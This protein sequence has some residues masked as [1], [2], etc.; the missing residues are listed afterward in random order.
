MWSR[1][2]ANNQE[3]AAAGAGAG[4]PP[5]G[6]AAGRP[7]P[8]AAA[9]RPPAGG[10]RSAFEA[11]LGFPPDPFQARAFDAIDDGH[12]VLVAV[13]TG[14]GKTVVAEYA[15]A[16]AL[17]QG[18]KAFYTTPIKALSNQKYRDFVGAYGA[19][20]VGLLTGDNSINPD[21]SVVVM[22]TEVLRNMIYEGSDTL[23][24][25]GVVVLDEV[26][27]LQDPYRGAVWEEVIIHLAPEVRLVCLSATVSNAEE[28]GA[29]VRTVRGGT[30][31]VIDDHRPVELHHL[32]AVSVRGADEVL[33]LP[34]F[35]RDGGR[36]VPNPEGSRWDPLG[37]GRSRRSPPSRARL[38]QGRPVPPR[39]VE[40]LEALAARSMVPAIYFLFSR[41]GCDEAVQQCLAAGLRLTS[42][43]EAEAV[44]G[45]AQRRCEGLGDGDLRLLGHDAWLSGL[46]AG[47]ASHHAGMV[48][49]MK[50]AVEEAFVA[51][52]VKVVFATET[53]ALGV[54]M[55][56][57]SVVIERLTKFTG[58]RHQMLTP[59]EYTQLAG[60][61]G[62]RGIDE[63]GYALVLWNRFATFDQVA[64]LASK[65]T[66][67]LSSSFRPTYNMAANLV[68]RYSPEQAHHLLN[69]SFAQY[70]IDREVV[71]VERRREEAVE[72]LR[73]ARVAAVCERGDLPDYA[74]LRA[75]LDA[76]RRARR[77]SERVAEALQGLRPG[78]VVFAGARVGPVAVLRRAASRSG[79]PVVTALSTRGRT[80]RL[81]VAGFREPPEPVGRI[82]IPEP[83]RPKSPEFRRN[84]VGRL[85]RVASATKARRGS[86]SH[87]EIEALEAEVRGHPVAGCPDLAAHLAEV[88]RAE[89]L[90]RELGRS[91]RPRSAHGETLARRFDHVLD[92]LRGRGYVEDWSVTDAGLT[93]SRIYSES[94]LLVAE[95]LRAGVFDGLDAPSMAAVLSLVTFE[96][97]GPLPPSPRWPTP[98]V[99]RRARRLEDLWDALTAEEEALGLP[100]TRA[101]DPG[102]ADAAHAWAAGES[103][104]EV[105]GADDLTGGDFVR[106]MKQLIDLLRQ[107]GDAGAGEVASTARAAA[108]ALFRGVVEASARVAT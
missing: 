45:I 51:G 39:R 79:D 15:V 18:D 105:L 28:F 77:G 101:P 96:Y 82:E 7:P 86:G 81:T 90:E 13:P 22:T 16:R 17:E 50:E 55:P 91:E 31:V 47:I 19:G 5:P 103:L 98:E 35:V 99:A 75:R 8:G 87:D 9:G 36:L 53:L 84:V 43:V 26:H 104:E 80:V 2:P 94:D 63:V 76:A 46:E 11:A 12:S 83:Y 27:Y 64:G 54:N 85:R 71:A 58:E 95:A 41:A 32:Y 78:D 33:V 88:Q 72:R 52:L 20:S 37:P 23:D 56:A 29:W 40:V 65:R 24:R 60:R 70:Q 74:R 6:A 108:D 100:E 61:A 92:V 106:N 102:F 89:R 57:R 48:P 73:Q 3:A 4:R 21:A 34:T 38:H 68:R 14:A 67:E 30:E 25:L 42:D 69:L 97:R 10:F 66:Y 1:D 107:V 59:G 62:R 93:L 49:P 44:R